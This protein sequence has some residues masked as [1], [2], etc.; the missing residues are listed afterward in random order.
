MEPVRGVLPPWKHT[1]SPERTFNAVPSG[2]GF[3]G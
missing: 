2:A 1:E 3:D